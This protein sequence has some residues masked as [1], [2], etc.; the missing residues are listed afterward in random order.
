VDELDFHRALFR[1]GHIIDIGAHDGALT[2]PLAA[3]PG[4]RVVA[5]EPLPAAFAR[6]RAALL[7]R[8]GRIPVH[9]ELH[10]SALGERSGEITL[11]VPV[12]GGVAQEQWASVAKD[13][14]AMHASDPRIEAVRCFRVPLMRLDD[15][16]L[17]DVTAIKLDAEGAEAEVI[18][19]AAATLGRCR[20]VL[21]IEIEERHR[22]GSTGAVPALL[23]GLGY[24]GFYEFWG[25]WR[26]IEGFDPRRMQRASPSPASF[27]VSDPYVFVF[28][29]I[30]PERREELRKLARLSD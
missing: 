10:Q 5:F 15:L 1:P 13:Y 22:P 8:Y 2:L 24:Q 4:A 21:S 29:F 20:P 9:V 27:E 25:E 17:P 12:V 23:A 18:R 30:P 28:Y 3:L 19:G 16:A 14:A 11:E 6:L 26:R 7:R